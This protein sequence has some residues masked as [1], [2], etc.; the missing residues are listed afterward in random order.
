MEGSLELSIKTQIAK[1]LIEVKLQNRD[2]AAELALTK[3]SMAYL[4]S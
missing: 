4:S 2:L 1:D 3:K